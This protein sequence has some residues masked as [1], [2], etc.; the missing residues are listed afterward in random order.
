MSPEP[1]TEPDIATARPYEGLASIYDYV[2]RHVD[3]VH[4]A[5]HV[6]SLLRR[7]GG[8]PH[9]LLELACGTGSVACALAAQGCAVTGYDI[10]EEMIC[11]AREKAHAQGDL[12]RF[13]VGDLRDLGEIGPFDGAICLYDSFNYLLSLA[14]VALA[15]GQVHDVLSPGAVFIFD[16]CTERNS[17]DHFGDVRD[18]ERGPG[19]VYS[20][21]SYYDADERLQFNTFNI[22]LEDGSRRQEKH[23]QR[24]YLHDDLVACIDASPFD[25][26]EALDGFTQRRGSEES[27]RVHFV[28]RRPVCNPCR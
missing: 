5:N 17:V 13:H 22:R 1:M 9:H 23:V 18:T 12:L 7:H 16:V 20:R 19:F 8:D 25:L 6:H 24:I 28:L 11:V 15:L 10:S 3:Y 26:L 4:W 2:M 14:D 21:H 27:D